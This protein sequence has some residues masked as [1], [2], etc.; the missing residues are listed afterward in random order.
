M[1]KEV[2][3]GA[4]I[5]TRSGGTLKYVVIR[6]LEGVCGF[7]KG[8]MEGSETEEETALREISEEVGLQV[9]LLPGF[10]AE[11]SYPLPRRPRVVKRVIYFLATCDGSQPLR[12]QRSE[13]SGAEWMDFDE[14]MRSFR[15]DGVKR[16][17]READAYL[18]EHGL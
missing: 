12:P 7:P 17:L 9:T 2:S 4:V 11:D 16:I 15:F 8:H 6:S 3:C 13:L 10:R 1:R 14:A 5:F 18:K